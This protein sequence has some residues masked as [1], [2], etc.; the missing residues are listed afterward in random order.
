[1][2]PMLFRY[3]S[4]VLPVLGMLLL[5]GCGGGGNADTA[6][7]SSSSSSSSG[8]SSS[9]SSI[10]VGDWDIVTGENASDTMSSGDFST[11]SINLGTLAVT[12]GSS[13]LVVGTTSDGVTPV[14]LNGTTVI[15]V[16][17]ETYGVTVSSIAPSSTPIE[18]V[19][20]G[21]Y[22][23]TVT[24]Y[25]DNDFK[26]NFSS[27]TISSSNGPAINIQSEQRAFVV[28]TGTNTLSDTSSYTTRYLADGTT[29]MDLKA[30][31]FSEGPL[32]FSGS[33]SLSATGNKKHVL[34]SDAHV[35]ITGG[36]LTLTG[37]KK[38]GIHTNNA[39]VMDGGTLTVTTA[40]SAGKGIKVE[41]KEDDTAPLGFIA[42]NGGTLSLTTYDKAITAS[43]EGDEDGETTS[44]ADDPDPRVTINGGTIAISTFGT[45]V[46]DVLAPE[47]IEAK[48][49]LTVNDGTIEVTTT[50]D[51]LNA[52]TGIV[53]NG[54]YIYAK[55]STNDAIDSNGTMT[56][57]GG[58]VVADGASGAEGGLDC[59][60]NA[61]TISG[62]TFVGIG[63]RNSTPTAVSQNTVSLQNVSSGLLV[64]K[65]ASA[66]VA[67]AYTMP[68]AST[69][70]LL[71]TS[72]L[73]TGTTYTVYSGGGS[74][75]SYSSLFHGLYF[76]AAAHSGG[77][78]GSSFTI[79]STITSL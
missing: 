10:S 14:T 24:M 65:D 63:G 20:S 76:G 53:I 72:A 55:S 11:L 5:S 67:F 33:G 69:A 22:G 34:C 68:E 70:V 79:T 21:T 71:G 1:V 78:K 37:N 75:G 42:I 15:T 46:E 58:V 77:A 59:D 8:T 57:A 13:S 41:G 38:D 48:S 49:V 9:A 73:A 56:I 54:G 61:F 6:A 2:K 64:V 50:D 29:A 60:Q 47:G 62:G 18:F 32:L 30:T 26:L 66:N 39:F 52:G 31:F 44:T 27:T 23:H 36:T 74:L 25:S 12:S 40:S 51:A 28:L 16:T 7:S 19:L 45:P 4:V 35:R 17:E 3:L 43:W